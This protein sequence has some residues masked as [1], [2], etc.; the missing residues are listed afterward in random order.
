MTFFFVNA[1]IMFMRIKTSFILFLLINLNALTL[2][3]QKQNNQ[4]CFGNTGAIDFN[5]VPPSF[6]TGAALSTFEGSA[7]VADRLTGS[8]LFYTDGVTVWNANN[9]VMTNGTGL[10]GGTASLLSS[11]TAAVIV[12]KPGNS[13]LFYIVTID[14][15]SSNN[16]VRYSVID[17]TLNGGLGD[18]VAGQ[19]NIFLFQTNSE[20]LEVVPASDGLGYWLITH[21][22][23]GNSFFSFKIDNAGIQ[24]IPVISQIGGTQGNGAGHMKINKQ[25]NKIAMG[26]LNLGSGSS[27]QIELYDFNNTTGVISNPTT[28]NYNFPVA[29]IYG[30]E[31]SPNGKVLYVSDLQNLIQYDITQPTPLAIENSAYQVS[32]S[33]STSLQLGIDDK[34]YVNAG[35]INAINCPNKLGAACGYQTNVIANQTGGGGY[36]L[37]KWVYYFSDTVQPRVNITAS[38]DT[39]LGT[40]ILFSFLNNQ[41]ISSVSWN[42]DDPASG[43]NNTSSLLNPTHLFS[44]AGNYQVT[45]IVTTSC[46]ADTFTFPKRVVDCTTICTGDITT[47]SDSCLQTVYAFLVNSNNAINSIVWDFNDPNAGVGNSSAL[48]NPNHVFTSPGIYTVSA[49]VMFSCG[50]DT[51]FKTIRIVQCVNSGFIAIRSAPDTCVQSLIRFNINTNQVIES[52]IE[53]NF[54]DPIS[55]ANNTSTLSTPTHQFSSPGTFTVQCILQINCT[56]PPNPN[57][58]IT[59]P[60]FYL[61]TVYKTLLIVDCDSVDPSDC[62]V[63]IPTAFTPN[64]DGNNDNFRP[65][66]NCKTEK[67]EL[68]IYNRWGQVVFTTRSQYNFWD[69]KLKNKDAPI[70]SYIYMLKYKFPLQDFKKV[71]GSILLIR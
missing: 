38:S 49:I 16:G 12:P 36:G 67:Y 71:N 51:I 29:L 57:N 65:K 24:T 27:T 13:S 42:F 33:N 47:S 48:L 50:I 37:P 14:E 7:S 58:P 11:T 20:K 5:T 60:C 17:M 4:W 31:F 63:F 23:P 55:G 39:C 25:F 34:I 53:W 1:R 15:Q 22:I 19:K 64:G 45:V 41:S 6:V 70:G 44:A 9:Q 32:N 43:P 69:G 26:L 61:D 21:D 66:A 56:S 18:V 10:L 40:P 35:S 68:V 52:L 46:E 54:G 30:I 28:W 59:T 3:A 62:K 2:F 8:L